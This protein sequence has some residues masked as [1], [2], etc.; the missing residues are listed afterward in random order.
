[1][2]GLSM[3]YIGLSERNLSGLLNEAAFFPF[4]HLAAMFML[5]WLI[6]LLK[7]LA[8]QSS[9]K[10]KPV[11][12]L[13]LLAVLITAALWIGWS[14]ENGLIA[15]V[16]ILLSYGGFVWMNV[17]FYAWARYSTRYVKIYICLGFTAFMLSVSL[18]YVSGISEVLYG[19]GC[20]VLL[21]LC[22]VSQ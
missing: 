8:D 16:H 20:S 4:A 6:Y 3:L 5:G 22:A 18:G 7:I 9:S 14:G 1:M 13:I 10:L 2:L 12:S 15:T 17:L 21:S 19:A 11:P